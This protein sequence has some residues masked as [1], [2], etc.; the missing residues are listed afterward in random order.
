[1]ATIA[2]PP[3]QRI[4]LHDVTWQTYECLLADHVERSAPRF[5]YDRGELEILSPGTEHEEDNRTIALFVEEVAFEFGIDVGNVGSMPFKRQEL[6]RGFEPDSGFYIAREEVVRGTVQIDLA[7]DP[8]PDLVI[9]IEATRSAIPK[10]P[11]YAAMGVPEVWR[12]DGERIAILRLAGD[13]YAAV[14][15]S[16]ALPP[17][18]AELLTRFVAESRTRRRTAWVRSVRKWAREQGRP[19]GSAG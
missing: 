17:L 5:T 11:L 13:G 8:P 10:L 4:V 1:M 7:V 14:A 19:A 12:T 15:T 16:A 3:E 6:Q 18:T 9:E 2:S